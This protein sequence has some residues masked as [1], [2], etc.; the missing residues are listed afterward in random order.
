MGDYTNLSSKEISNKA[1]K[2]NTGS[3]LT[4]TISAILGPIIITILN[5]LNNTNNTILIIALSIICCITIVSTI[6][7][8]VIVNSNKGAVHALQKDLDGIESVMNEYFEK[9]GEEVEIKKGVD[10]HQMSKKIPKKMVKNS[11]N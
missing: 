10:V 6:V 8:I 2:S 4:G 9:M 1:Q 3:V 5:Q 7:G 11:T